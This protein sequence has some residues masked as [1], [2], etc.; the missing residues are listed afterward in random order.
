MR[1]VTTVLQAK[2]VAPN[3]TG[4]ARG[5]SYRSMAI[6]SVHGPSVIGTKLKSLNRFYTDVSFIL[7][8]DCNPTCVSF[9]FTLTRVCNEPASL[10]TVYMIVT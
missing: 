1:K 5:F 3:V 4:T 8:Y 10:M 9:Q 7:E 2:S 6:Q